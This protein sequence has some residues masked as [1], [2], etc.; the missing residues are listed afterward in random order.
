MR[1]LLLAAALLF[2]LAAQA[3][4]ADS[5]VV[6][7]VVPMT[8]GTSYPASRALLAVCTVAGNISAT[9]LDGSTLTFPA[10]VGLNNFPFAVT[11]VSA[12]TATCTYYNGR[13]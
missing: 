3:Q 4:L 7:G 1:K 13:R 6:A 5:P 9:F 12:S 10:V 8:V 11:L 2:P